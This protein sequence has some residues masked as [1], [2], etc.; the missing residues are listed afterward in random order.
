M[1]LSLVVTV[2]VPVSRSAGLPLQVRSKSAASSPATGSLKTTLIEVTAVVRGS[3]ETSV[4]SAVGP[5]VSTSIDRA[6]E[7]GPTFPAASV[8]TVVME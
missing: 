2:S 7:G 1:R 5:A 6:A 4:T 3:G 8:A